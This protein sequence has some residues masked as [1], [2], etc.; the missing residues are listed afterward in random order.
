MCERFGEFELLYGD[1]SNIKKRNWTLIIL[2]VSNSNQANNNAVINL[3]RY[4]TLDYTTVHSAQN[5]GVKNSVT[6]ALHKLMFKQATVT[7]I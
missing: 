3:H 6:L 7:D 2:N 1:S 5:C 4:P